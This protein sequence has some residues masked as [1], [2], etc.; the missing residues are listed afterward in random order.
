MLLP[1]RARRLSVP[2]PILLGSILLLTLA[3]YAIALRHDFV[4]WDD[5]LLII[6]NPAVRQFSFAALRQMFST[7]DP[8]LYIPLTLLSFNIEHALF[9]LNPMVFHATNILLHLINTLFVFLIVRHWSGRR[10]VAAAAALLFGI[11]PLN[12]EA[13]NWISGRKDLLSST[14]FLLAY[15][16]YLRLRARGDARFPRAVLLLF[17]AGLLAKVTVVTL[18]V[19]LLLQDLRDRR[20][21]R[22]AIPEKIPFFALALVFGVVALHGK[23]QNLEALPLLQT[24]LITAKSVVFTIGKFVMPV[25]LSVAYPVDPAVSLASADIQAAILA[26]LWAVALIVLSLRWTREGLFLALFALVT[27]SPN[28]ATFAKAG[29]F[30]YASDRYAYL[31][32]VALCAAVGWLVAYFLALAP[33]ARMRRMTEALLLLGTLAFVF[34]AVTRSRVWKTSKSLYLDAIAKAPSVHVMHYNLG[35]VYIGERDFD[36]ALRENRAALALKTDYADAHN[37]IGVVLREQGRHEEA[38]REFEEA[39]RIAPLNPFAHNNIGIMLLEEGKMN[40]AIAAFERSIEGDRRYGLAYR[41]LADALG[42]QGRYREALE[43]TR[44][45]LS[46]DFTKREELAALEDQLKKL[47]AQEEGV[48]R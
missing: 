9:G 40:D 45:A 39:L 38:R 3:T 43:A 18:P 47:D 12:V 8:E 26:L 15:L 1:M 34:L 25:R 24:V 22:A 11:H 36:A 10:T 30:F 33:H 37:N 17:L 28:F 32:L 14:F 16:Q 48:R 5:D 4:T 27:M 19:V 42:K 13:V 6:R 2:V 35:L 21:M 20:S 29:Q 7:Y 23:T 31:P 44:T 46:L 41:N